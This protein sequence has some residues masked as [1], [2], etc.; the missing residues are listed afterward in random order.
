MKHV[1]K[2][3]GGPLVLVHGALTGKTMWLPSK[4]VAPFLLQ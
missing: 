1:I 2:G 4:M 3:F